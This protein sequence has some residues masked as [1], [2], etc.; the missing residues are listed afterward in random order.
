MTI[1][2]SP[3]RNMRA[4]RGVVET[5]R[6]QRDDQP[7]SAGRKE[8]VF[9]GLLIALIGA[10]AWLWS[11]H[12]RDPAIL[13]D[14]QAPKPV[15]L[16][17]VS[18]RQPSSIEDWVS[19]A[20]V[21]GVA[22]ELDA[23]TDIR[24]LNRDRSAIRIDRTPVSAMQTLANSVYELT[25]PAN[26][27]DVVTNTS[28][29][30][31]LTLSLTT[32][33]VAGDDLRAHYQ[34]ETNGSQLQG[35]IVGHLDML[36]DLALRMS[37][38]LRQA[39]D[40]PARATLTPNIDSLPS[41][42][43][44]QKILI[45]AGRALTRHNFAE[46]VAQLSDLE[47]LEPNSALVKRALAQAY[48]GLGY[49]N[50]AR[51]YAIDAVRLGANLPR[52]AL[53]NTR[54][55]SHVLHHEWN[56]AEELLNALFLLYPNEYTYGFKLSQVRT[57]IGDFEGALR[58]LEQL[59][60]LSNEPE[61]DSRID[62][63]AANAQ[64]ARGDW[65]TA[66]MHAQ[67]ALEKANNNDLPSIKALAL[68]WLNRLEKDP[69]QSLIGQAETLFA[70]LSNTDG[71]IA[72]ITRMGTSA[73]ER[74]EYQQSAKQLQRAVDLAKTTGNESRLTTAL[75]ALAITRDL[76]GELLQGLQIKEEVLGIRRRRGNQIGIGIA[77]ENLA[78]SH[79]KLGDTHKAR[80]RFSEAKM[81]FLKTG[82]LIGSAWVPWHDGRLKLLEGHFQA[83]KQAFFTAETNAEEKPEGNY[84][85]HAQYQILLIRLLEGPGPVETAE[86]IRKAQR[87]REDYAA[88]LLAPD[89]AEA[90]LLQAMLEHHDG[91]REAA[92][93]HALEAR[94]LFRTQ[95]AA[96]YELKANTELVRMGRIESCAETLSAAASSQ[97]RELA[98]KALVTT[99]S[100]P[101]V[102]TDLTA[103]KEES[104]RLGLFEPLWLATDIQDAAAATALA[105]RYGW[106]VRP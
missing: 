32:N 29:T 104:K 97:H 73:R 53:L 98:L 15:G 79:Y 44:A 42:A 13:N 77:L 62:L 83:A 84:E 18:S 30:A 40:L 63:A 1:D 71:Q 28:Q 2:R 75:G 102:Q 66:V 4:I 8:L 21:T 41:T 49:E 43:A 88:A 11:S 33:S 105:K 90:L 14:T 96:Y 17:V 100:C 92:V 91:Q 58:L 9:S 5:L 61:Q 35:Q 50:D 54:A 12:S 101:G 10:S 74:G 19:D 45:N 36:A 6:T 86:L 106:P 82:D 85:L 31:R 34:L 24:V 46:A 60:K 87:L 94:N 69:D 38:E 3:H 80:E 70:K 67:A 81:Q 20:L 26:A 64:Y 47:L 65:Q 99:Y 23:A 16:V 37:V 27:S 25:G 39:L 68:W 95:G 72:A 51:R 22:A 78:I 57:T 103:I 93:K 76:Q 89:E 52:E 7:V 55:E 59:R 48:K 56:E